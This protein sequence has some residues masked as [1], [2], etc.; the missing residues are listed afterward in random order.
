MA[1]EVA[2]GK[3]EDTKPSFR[4]TYY[5]FTGRGEPLR[6][7]AT[8]GG[9]SFQDRFIGQ[10]EFKEAKARGEMRWS[11]VPELT[12]L[13]KDGQDVMKLGQSNSCI[14]FVG[15]LG[16]AY[17]KSPLLRALCD[18]VM[19]S[20]EDLIGI[21]A[22]AVFGGDDKK[23]DEVCTDETKLPYWLAKFEARLEENAKR[24]SKNGGFVGDSF[25]VADCKVFS[26][27]VYVGML[28][29]GKALIGRYERFGAFLKA[30][31]E[32]E[33]IK[34][35]K[36]TFDANIEKY[37]ADSTANNDF[38]YAGKYIESAQAVVVPTPT[39]RVTYYPFT[40]RGEPLRLAAALGGISF[41]D[42]FVSQAEF[43]AAKARGDMRWSG[44]PELTVLNE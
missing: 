19:D 22:G 29:K 14:R 30:F 9:L 31:G 24:G 23:K 43:K 16:G 13:D 41:E 10:G 5:P 8:L 7:A 36:A 4:V 32:D 38:I 21:A 39:F 15:A 34:A 37:K 2:E 20:A 28:P 27:V 44:V 17:P 11:G 33:R 42:R 3:A 18:E 35:F 1:V 26:A 6:L 12:V 40:G 25:T